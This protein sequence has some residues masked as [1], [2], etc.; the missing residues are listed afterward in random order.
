MSN[1]STSEVRAVEHR[2]DWTDYQPDW[3]IG[4][5][6]SCGFNGTY[7]EC[8]N[9][10]L[11]EAD[12]ARDDIREYAQKLRSDSDVYQRFDAIGTAAL[13]R[14]IASTLERKIGDRT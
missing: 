2:E 9:Y 5:G 10:R 4:P 3:D 6:C 11:A 13:L 8:R 12:A 14:T 1:P 7:E